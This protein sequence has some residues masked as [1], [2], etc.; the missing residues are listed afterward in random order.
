MDDVAKE[1]RKIR[2]M[3]LVIHASLVVIVL[4]FAGLFFG[5]LKAASA[6]GPRIA[7]IRKENDLLRGENVRLRTELAANRSSS[8]TP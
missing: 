7:Q 6:A 2:K 5:T 8:A 4:L 1:L 3:L